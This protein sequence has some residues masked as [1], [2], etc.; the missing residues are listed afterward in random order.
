M[1]DRRTLLIEQWRDRP[2]V[3]L[4]SIETCLPV[5]RAT[6]RSALEALQGLLDD[7]FLERTPGGLVLTGRGRAM[8]AAAVQSA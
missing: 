2:D 8:L 6:N 3:A 7:G 5:S 4:A 1:H